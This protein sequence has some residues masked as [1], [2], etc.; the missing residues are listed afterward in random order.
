[1]IGKCSPTISGMYRVDQQWFKK[2]CTDPGDQYDVQGFDSYGY[3]M[4]DIDRAGNAEMAYWGDEDL[5][6]QVH[7]EWCDVTS[8]DQLVDKTLEV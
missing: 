3:N 7:S 4:Q 1:M 6:N 5:Y 2:N 8:L